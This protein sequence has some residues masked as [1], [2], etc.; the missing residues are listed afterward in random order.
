MQKLSVNWA[1]LVN[2][3]KL[4]GTSINQAHLVNEENL[5]GTSVNQAHSITKGSYKSVVSTEF[6]WLT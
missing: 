4:D 1:H 3:G 5:D 2:E 6:T